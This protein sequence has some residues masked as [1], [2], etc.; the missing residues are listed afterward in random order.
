[1]PKLTN[2]EEMKGQH[3]GFSAVKIDDLKASEYTL[4][5]ICVDV[6]SSV[7]TFAAALEEALANIVTS[8]N[9]SPRKNNLLLRVVTFN[10]RVEEFHGFKHLYECDGKDYI[11]KL[12]PSGTTALIDSAYNALDATATFGKALSDKDYDVNGVFYV[13]TDGIDNESSFNPGKIKEVLEK[14]RQDEDMESIQAFLIGVNTEN[15][16]S[17]L[18]SFQLE[19][20]LDDFLDLEDASDTTLAKLANFVSQ[21]ISSTSQLLAQGSQPTSLTF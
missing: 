20:G 11:G 1:M 21:S 18:K 7:Y 14:V 9:R 2:L 16:S 10:Q 6:S 5:T 8:C 19:A 17:Y 3:F 13:I 15:C 4:V 12:H